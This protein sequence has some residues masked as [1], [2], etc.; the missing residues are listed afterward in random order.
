VQIFK[1][2]QAPFA[3]HGSGSWL[4]LEDLAD[5]KHAAYKHICRLCYRILKLS[6]HDYRKN[7]VCVW[8][9]RL[10][11]PM[12]AGCEQFIIVVLWE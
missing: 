8:H 1:I 11:L 5:P 12:Q 4:K 2:L 6:Q 9:F 10:R 3:D 7:Q